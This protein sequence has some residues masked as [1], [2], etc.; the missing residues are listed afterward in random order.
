MLA[1]HVEDFYSLRC[2][3]LLAHATP[4]MIDIDSDTS[5]VLSLE[6]TISFSDAL[7]ILRKKECLSCEMSQTCHINV[8]SLEHIQDGRYTDTTRR[9]GPPSW[10]RR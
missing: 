1:R 5:E 10:T 2:Q 7:V 6:L 3:S 8:V 9:R 4:D